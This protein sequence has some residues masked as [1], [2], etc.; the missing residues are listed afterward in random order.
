MFAI[1]E[2]VIYS[3]NGDERMP[4]S[5]PTAS[6]SDGEL[7][8][9]DCRIEARGANMATDS[10][11]LVPPFW[12][13]VHR[14]GGHLSGGSGGPTAIFCSSM[15]VRECWCVSEAIFGSLIAHQ[16]HTG[17]PS[18][19]QR[20]SFI[21]R[22][23]GSAGVTTAAMLFLPSPVGRHCGG[24]EGVVI[25]KTWDALCRLH[26]RRYIYARTSMGGERKP[27]D[28][29]RDGDAI[30]TDAFRCCVELYFF[31]FT[32]KL[33]PEFLRSDEL[34]GRYRCLK[35]TKPLE[36]KGSQRG[37]HSGLMTSERTEKS[38]KG[39]SLNYRR[40]SRLII[41]KAELKVSFLPFIALTPRLLPWL[42]NV[43]LVPAC[44]ARW[45]HSSHSLEKKSTIYVACA[46]CNHKEKEGLSHVSVSK[47]PLNFASQDWI[48]L[49]VVSLPVTSQSWSDLAT[50]RTIHNVLQWS[51][52]LYSSCFML[53]SIHGYFTLF[54]RPAIVLLPGYSSASCKAKFQLGLENYTKEQHTEF[55]AVIDPRLSGCDL[56]A[57]LTAF[58]SQNN[59][60]PLIPALGDYDAEER[61]RYKR[62]KSLLVH[63]PMS[64]RMAIVRDDNQTGFSYPSQQQTRFCLQA[65]KTHYLADEEGTSRWWV[66]IIFDT[67]TLSVGEGEMRGRWSCGGMLEWGKRGNTPRK[68][69]GYRQRPAHVPLKKI[70]WSSA[71]MEGREVPEKTR[72][73]TESSG[74]I[75]TCESPV[76]RPGIEPGSPWWEASV[77][78]SQTPLYW[79][80][81]VNRAS[82]AAVKS[83][84]RAAGA[85]TAGGFGGCRGVG[86]RPSL[87]ALYS[88]TDVSLQTCPDKPLLHSSNLLPRGL[89]SPTL[90]NSEAFEQFRRHCAPPQAELSSAVTGML[91]GVEGTPLN[92][93]QYS[94]PTS[95]KRVRFPVGS[96]PDFRTSESCWTMPLV[97]GFFSR[98]S[99]SPHPCIAALLRAQL[100]PHSSALKTRISRLHEI[101]KICIFA[102]ACSVKGD[103]VVARP[104]SRSEGAIR[105]TVTRTNYICNSGTLLHAMKDHSLNN[106]RIFVLFSCRLRK[107]T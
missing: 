63:R 81:A 20:S 80:L 97:G 78:I 21:H 35:H 87:P 82:Q 66:V 53:Y 58:T 88:L 51:E 9:N 52:T 3:S 73:P 26:G 27:N 74:T 98:L 71:G 103:N 64:A 22:M 25:P 86:A 77:L 56:R 23:P 29:L 94:P 60:S 69:A 19:L 89:A 45:Q 65:L 46:P 33:I 42:H 67:K 91:L 55:S 79:L 104:K 75:P 100:A 32:Q 28:R 34:F 72:R 12:Q 14:F 8:G 84:R 36:I 68:P 106:A 90:Q 31:L 7:N 59:T 92:S 101:K 18:C 85:L 2:C 76:T 15:S 11:I 24:G 62:P 16:E 13:P 40:V 44:A 17:P 43:Q 95:A 10:A 102:Q 57:D 83:M 99:R 37:S 30:A 1:L 48:V 49:R 39:H 6:A 96:L 50:V 54:S 41:N 47:E 105:A 4:A 70:I 38:E 61:Q 93:E 5:T 107:I